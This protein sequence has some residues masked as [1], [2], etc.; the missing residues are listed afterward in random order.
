MEYQIISDIHLELWSDK[1]IK[2]TDIITPV[3]KNV[4]VAGDIGC[5]FED[6][7]LEFITYLSFV[8]E[9]V[10]I[11]IGN[12]EYY[13]SDYNS[14]L[15]QVKSIC[16]KAGDNVYFLDNDCVEINENLVIIGSTL[17][18]DISKHNFY[19]IYKDNLSFSFDEYKRLFY[20]SFDFLKNKIE[21]YK[22]KKFKIIVVTHY[23]PTNNIRFQHPRYKFTTLQDCFI[24]NTNLIE[25][26]E[27]DFWIFGHTHYSFDDFI[28]STR[29]ICNPVG[30]LT[31]IT[32]YFKDK[33][34]TIKN[35]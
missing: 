15:K 26:L 17:W 22:R 35:S 13:Y 4:I 18:S 28:G 19:D 2:F 5:P 27:P 9:K 32:N 25:T 3:T 33:I 1:H 31:E 34:F 12:H 29:V 23:V 24:S 21:E 7:Y 14:T 20:K 30:R 16:L 11:I 8:F 6:I 10:Y